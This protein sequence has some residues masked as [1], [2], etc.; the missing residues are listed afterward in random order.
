MNPAV[1]EHALELARA[2]IEDMWRVTRHALVD[3][4]RASTG[5][6]SNAETSP[7]LANR[8]RKPI[9]SARKRVVAGG[10]GNIEVAAQDLV[11]EQL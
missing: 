3:S 2:E 1:V 4:V 5:V 6:A 10:A 7:T 9:A 11:K 8:Q